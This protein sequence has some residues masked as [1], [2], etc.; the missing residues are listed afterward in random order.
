M[1]QLYAGDSTAE[2]NT[3]NS[4]KGNDS[5]YS[6]GTNISV[7]ADEGDDYISVYGEKVTISGGEGDDYINS[8]GEKVTMSGGD[9][10]DTFGWH[11]GNLTVND[12]EEGERVEVGV[13]VTKISTTSAGNVVFTTDGGKLTLKDAANKTVTYLDTDGTEK[14]YRLIT[15]TKSADTYSSTIDNATVKALGGNDSII[16]SAND[17]TIEAGA[18]KDTIQNSGANV[19][20]QY[21]AGKDKIFGFNETSKLSIS[22]EYT[23]KFQDDDFIITVGKGKITLAGVSASLKSV[24]VNGAEIP[25]NSWHLDGT[26]ATYGTPDETLVT[27]SGVKS[28]NGLSLS[29]KTV[30]VSKSSLGTNEVK[31]SDGYKL[32]LADDVPVSKTDI[33][34]L[35]RNSVAYY[36]KIV[37]K[38][39]YSLVDNEIIYNTKGTT[40]LAA[41]KGIKNLDGLSVSGNTIKIAGTSLASKV[42]VSGSAYTFDFASDFSDATITGNGGDDSIITR[43]K[44]IL[45]KAGVGDDLIKVFGSATTVEGS[46]GSDVFAF[47]GKGTNVIGDYSPEDVISLESGAATVSMNDKDVILAAGKGKTSVVGSKDKV[48][49]YVD[50]LNEKQTYYGHAEDVAIDEATITLLENYSEDKFDVADY[51]AQLQTIDAS[52]VTN[53]LEIIGNKKANRIVGT[54]EDDLIDAQAGADELDGGSGSDSLIGG[55]GNDTL[56]GGKGEDVFLY[57]DGDGN[58]LIL[59]YDEDDAIKFTAGTVS[60]VVTTGSDV[61]FSVGK[62]KIT[63]AGGA[64]K[65]IRYEDAL[66]DEYFYPVNFNAAGTSAKLMA[67]YGLDDFDINDYDEY[68]N[69]VETIDASSVSHDLFITANKLANVITGGK[70]NDT[71]NGGKGNDTLQGSVG[72]DVFVYSAGN[73]VVTDYEEEDTIQIAKGSVKKISTTSALSVV[74]TVGSG[75][76]TVKDAGDKVVTYT[77]ADGTHFYPVNF[78]D[79]G[80][81][82]TLLKAYGKD[83]FNIAEFSQYV[84]SVETIDAS[85]VS[86]GLIISANKLANVITATAQDDFI[87]GAAGADFITGGKGADTLYGKDGDDTLDGGAGADQ[88]IGGAGDDSISAGSGND[89]LWGDAGDDTLSGGKGEDVF[90]YNN[91]DGKDIISDYVPDVDKV[92]ILSGNVKSVTNDTAGDVTFKIGSGQIVFQNSA[93]KYIE[94]VDGSGEILKRYIPR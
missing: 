64:N 8:N 39:G 73:D 16:N 84:G 28:V 38:T 42:T 61:I 88:L 44:N 13:A 4:G 37:D 11:G 22:G 24:N 48:I 77:D 1:V 50:T 94:L 74:L 68:K 58:D 27:I 14:F 78:S 47:K 54:S 19:T 2:N 12:Y 72:S 21:G 70:G 35:L 60:K 17:V 83:D 43:G 59:D 9:G 40:T 32:A 26:R 62:G 91:G 3:I 63:V 86:H 80:T 18:G 55:L 57:A 75:K 46:E 33:T 30:T 66:A 23:T 53:P 56:T 79:D 71:I 10:N 49:T 29:G 93:S 82:V 51:G 65:I 7:N 87:D 67:A 31:I 90:I 15:L 85:K 45:L 20:F 41:I 89:T 92:I 6:G 69:S 25:M 81:S 5:I 34:W 76:I 52:A 36:Q